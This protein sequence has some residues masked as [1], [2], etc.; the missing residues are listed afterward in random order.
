MDMRQ[1]ALTSA[2]VVLLLAVMIPM[3]ALAQSVSMIDP[4][5]AAFD[6]LD[7]PRWIS[8]I[9]TESGDTYA[10]VASYLDNA[11]QVMDV[12][13]PTAPVPVVSLRDGENGFE[14]LGGGNAIAVTTI[15]G[16]TYALVAGYLDNAIQII[17]VTDP[18]APVPVA[19]FEDNVGGFEALN[20]PFDIEIITTDETIYALVASWFDGAVQVVDISDPTS[21]IPVLA[22]RDG[23]GGFEE[24]A[25]AIGIAPINTPDGLYALVIG[26]ADHGI[27]IV[28]MTDPTAPS[29]AGIFTD[30]SNLLQPTTIEVV[31][32]SDTTYAIVTSSAK[33]YIY[34]LDVTDLAAPSPVAIIRDNVDG[35]DALNLVSRLQFVTVSDNTYMLATGFGDNSIQIVDMTDPTA[36][37]PAGVIANGENGFEG[38]R[39]ASSMAT[40]TVSGNTYLLVTSYTDDSIQVIDIT[41]PLIP[42]AVTSIYDAQD[43]GDAD[44][45]SLSDS[46]LVVLDTFDTESIESRVVS[47]V[48]DAVLM[49]S[50]NGEDAFATMNPQVT[51][52]P[53]VFVLNA[54]ASK[55]V[56]HNVD[57]DLESTFQNTLSQA[58]RPLSV[59][60]DDLAI[61]GG[62]W[63]NHM[64]PHPETSIIQEKRSWLYAHDGYIFGSGYYLHDT[65]VQELV[66]SAVDI[67]GSGEAAVIDVISSADGPSV[68]VHM[69]DVSDTFLYTA[70]KSYEQIIEELE[71]YGHIWLSYTAQNPSVSAHQTV[72]MWL[73]VHDEHIFGAG[74]YLPDSRIQSLAE[75]AQLLY[76]S[77][78]DTAFE[79]IT[80]EAS[81]YSDELYPFVLE[82]DTSET[83]AHGAYPHLL[84]AVPTGSLHRAD[85]PWPQIQE[86][87]LADG[88]AWAS[89]VFKNP[90]TQ[91]D[92][93][94]RSY[95]Q[96]HDGYI[97]ISGYYLPDARVQAMVDLAV[98][99][100]RSGE[101]SFEGINSGADL[102]PDDSHY[103]TVLTLTG[104]A[105][106]KD[107]PSDYV[108]DIAGLT[109]STNRALSG[110]YYDLVEDGSVWFE[111]ATIN[112][113]TGTEQI[114]RS[115]LYL[116]DD[117]LFQ[118]G[119][120]I[121]D[122]EVQSAVDSAVFLYQNEGM[123]A[124]DMITPEVPADSDALYPFV[125]EFDTAATVAHG[126]YPDLVGEVPTSSLLQGE[127]SWSQIQEEL[128]AYGG[129]WTSYTFIN[130]DTDTRQEKRTWLYLYDEYVFASGYYISDSQVQAIVHNAIL[131]YQSD[132]DNA[133]AIIDAV[134]EG[135]P[136]ATY[137][138]VIN[139]T[140]YVIEAHGSDPSRNGSIS[141]ALTHADRSVEDILSDLMDTSGT[142]SHYT[143]INPLTGEAEMKRS[144]LSLHDG[145]IFGSGYYDTVG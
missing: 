123:A 116:Y 129:T 120:Y 142:W 5:P 36:P 33:S 138:F 53:S 109:V 14:A 95:L 128:L 93:L 44:M 122:S 125:M 83:V 87:L 56:V 31:T 113:A 7:E 127:K 110:L 105:W 119:Y 78:G 21:P 22:I 41:D 30:G 137:P 96:L 25:G 102:D 133:L 1:Y 104:T 82:F 114:K 101:D 74:Y 50:I 75:G 64:F 88:D 91:T 4:Q 32:I 136:M 39:G 28:D 6:A 9:T 46:A 19:S 117:L 79:I 135:E 38:L 107:T 70:A 76:Q 80:P 54:D 111:R 35:F 52:A 45:D 143:T 8:L 144:W 12:T 89:Y 13:D 85:I 65:N 18:T 29:P 130:P 121:P 11:V 97:F 132:P 66:E 62:T 3:S 42:H 100:Y 59:I 2:S 61:N 77:N 51:Y 81:A 108:S 43:T 124:F 40:V 140:T 84:G 115:W 92:Q 71:V 86:E 24:L 73:G 139:A 60:L 72:R 16:S 106:A 103:V 47:T 20:G 126:A 63:V 48:T 17:D 15:S 131:T 26:Y 34:I 112:L 27:Q 134:S 68:F 99:N 145:Y 118:S 69:D 37:S 49:Y 90:D 10:L 57:P 23:V 141:L 67:Y 58:D 55:V 98:S 94:K